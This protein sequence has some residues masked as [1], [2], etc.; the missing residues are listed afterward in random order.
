MTTMVPLKRSWSGAAVDEGAETRRLG[1]DERGGDAAA[2]SSSS[3]S[4][5]TTARRRRRAATRNVVN[6]RMSGETRELAA[7][8]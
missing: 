4:T 6:S 1:A 8:G 7:G 2:A 5:M 3:S